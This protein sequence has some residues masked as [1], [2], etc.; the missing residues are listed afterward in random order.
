MR[1]LVIPDANN[2]DADQ[3]AHPRCLIGVFVI[4]CLGSIIS[5]VSI[6]EISS[7]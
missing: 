1:K 5:L 3:P 7:L 2:N 4:H 6:P